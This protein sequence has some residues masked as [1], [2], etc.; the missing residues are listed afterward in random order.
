M[1]S[2]TYILLP[3]FANLGVIFFFNKKKNKSIE[4]EP[5]QEYNN[6]L[7]RFVKDGT[8]RKIGESVSINGDIVIIKS[9]SRFL[10]VP[11]KHIEEDGKTLL[12][13]GLVDFGKAYEIGEEWRKVSFRE[14]DQ[15]AGSE[16]KNDGP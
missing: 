6:L 16:G 5:N 3:V 2:S 11:L 14:I 9:G 4:D 10:G 7:C 15:K 12:V 8:G 1:L 13:K